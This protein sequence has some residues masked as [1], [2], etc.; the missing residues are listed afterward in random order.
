[1]KSFD[2]MK[3]FFSKKENMLVLILV[4]ILLMVIVIP[5]KS[6]H[7]GESDTNQEKEETE[8][9]NESNTENSG[10]YQTELDNYAQSLENRVSELVSCMDGVGKVKVMIT[11]ASSG[12]VIVEK[13]MPTIRNNITE[14]DS[15][16]GNRTTG[17]YQ[18][19]ETT[20]YITDEAGNKIPY[21][22]KTI[23]PIVEGVTVVAQGG[24]NPT[25]QKNISEV[26]QALFHIELHK[27]KV[28]KM[29][30]ASE[31]E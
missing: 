25:V 15:E 10:Q 12:E 23:E 26:I 7:K 16:G 29:R 22:I 17:E 13:D 9:R 20:V 4:G 3:Q 24:D 14:N 18:N 27:I 2:E 8:S 30:T 19:E 28:V 11:L 21:V 1:M 5:T 6:E 31:S